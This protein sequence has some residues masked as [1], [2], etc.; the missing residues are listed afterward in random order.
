MTVKR[1]SAITLLSL[2][3]LAAACS[4]S[5]STASIAEAQMAKGITDKLASRAPETQAP[6]QLGL[7]LRT[8]AFAFPLL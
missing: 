5:F 3:E 7:R 8:L 6:P 1:L 2:A 4:F